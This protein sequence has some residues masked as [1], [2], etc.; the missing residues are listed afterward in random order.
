MLRTGHR[1]KRGRR[2]MLTTGPS[3]KCV[4]GRR[5]CTLP[6]S[7]LNRPWVEECTM[8]HFNNRSQMKT[9]CKGNQDSRTLYNYLLAE[10]KHVTNC[11]L[12]PK[13][14]QTAFQ[15][16]FNLQD[17][18]ADRTRRQAMVGMLLQTEQTLHC[19][20]PGMVGMLLQTE[21]TLHCRLPGMVGMLL[22]TG[23]T[24]HCRRLSWMN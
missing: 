23:Q 4:A 24:L 11:A 20:L 9:Q 8:G 1:W 19:R 5:L 13:N 3:W 15:F 7:G 21:Q 6:T 22:Q 18:T 12:S 10:I 16:L 17:G 14:Q 2:S